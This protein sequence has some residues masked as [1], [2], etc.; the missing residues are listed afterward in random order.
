MEDYH[1]IS[2]CTGKKFSF[3]E[4]CEYCDSH[5]TSEP[6][7]EFNG[8]EFNI[9]D[10]CLNP[11]TPIKITDKKGF[12]V[13]IR[14]AQSENNRWSYG[15][16]YDLIWES[17]SSPCIFIDDNSDK[18]F[19]TEREAVIDA[20]YD[21]EDTILRSIEK[22]NKLVSLRKNEEEYHEEESSYCMPSEDKKAKMYEKFL[23]SV[24]NERKA[25]GTVQLSLF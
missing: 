16:S 21:I 2:R 25:Y 17:R 6:A 8:F 20:F 24:R 11:N 19:S 18:S 14:T 10:V 13:E 12:Y 4:W 5:E 23:L 22:C 15:C 7:A 1:H 3:E 9:F